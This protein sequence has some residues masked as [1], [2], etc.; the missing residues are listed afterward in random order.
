MA[1]VS[2]GLVTAVGLSAPASCAAIRAGIANPSETRFTDSDGEWIMAQQVA[3][4]KRWQGRMRLARMGAMA[5]VEALAGVPREEWA[6][7]P[8]LLCVAEP[9]RPGRLEGLDE[10]LLA[11][12]AE[13][14][15]T[16]PARGSG[17]VARGRVGVAVALAHARSLIHERGCAKVLILAVDSLL[18]W[19][20]LGHY[21]ANRRLLT[22]RNSDGFLPGEGAGALLVAASA[23]GAAMHC[24]GIGF[25][26]EDARVD[27]DQPLRAEGL[28]QAIRAALA[29]AGC[30]MHDIDY[31]IADLSGEQYYFKEATLALARLL[32]R[33]KPEFDLWHPAECIGEAGAVVGAAAVGVACAADAKAYA[34]GPA[35]LVHLSNDDGARAAFT[36]VGGAAR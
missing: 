22:P 19:R 10:S 3:V 6:R 35:V 8:I 14:L 15:G 36:L 18:G 13:M 23:E 26:L 25:S 16:Q 34:K 5:A 11:T 9:D 32:R 30:A 12:L 29:E 2:T 1:I 21:E 27:S 33:V 31:R 20:T 28:S 24:T 4:G 7:T 17:V